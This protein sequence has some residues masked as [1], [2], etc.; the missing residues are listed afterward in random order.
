VVLITLLTFFLGAGHFAHSIA[1]SGEVLAAVLGGPLALTSYLTWLAGAVLGNVVG[2][3]VIVA[4]LNY[5]Q[6][7]AKE[8]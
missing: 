3:V 7:H 4:L 1:G 5:G 6:V 2:G 8:P